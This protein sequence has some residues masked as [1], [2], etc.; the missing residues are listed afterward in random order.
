MSSKAERA[1]WPVHKG[2]VGIDEDDDPSAHLT[3]EECLSMICDLSL[4]GWAFMG[5]PDAPRRLQRH[6]LRVIRRPG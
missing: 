5:K 1:N 6:I 2:R 4:D 3:P